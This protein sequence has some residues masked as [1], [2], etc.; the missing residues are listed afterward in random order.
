MDSK[1]KTVAIILAA[2]IGSRM[3]SDTTKQKM[4]ICGKSVLLRT[5]LAFENT[6]SVDGIVVVCRKE[7]LDFA[8]AELFGLKKV[9]DFVPGGE[10]RRDSASAGFSASRGADFVAIH[11]AARCMITPEAIDSVVTAA[12]KHGA[13]SAVGAVNDTVKLVNAD[14]IIEKTVPRESLRFAE[15]PQVFSYRIY[16]K[17]L[18]ANAKNRVTDDNMM[19]EMIG[20]EIKAVEIDCYNFK[21]TTHADIEYAQF[22][23]E[24]G[25]AE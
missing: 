12:H 15:T 8:K 7:E 6:K 3:K 22:L 25:Y 18:G 5:A 14:G 1:L 24:K 20:A 16:E 10:T 17:A 19:A 13:A 2:G 23:V 9:M 4:Q 11:G 21:I